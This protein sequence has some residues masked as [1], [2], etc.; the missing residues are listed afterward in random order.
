MSS[1]PYNFDPSGFIVSALT[2]PSGYMPPAGATSLP[3]THVAPRVNSFFGPNHLALT[4]MLQRALMGQAAQQGATASMVQNPALAR[5]QGGLVGQAFT[6]SMPSF[7]RVNWGPGGNINPQ[8]GWNA[9][10]MS[11]AG[12]TP[13]SGGFLGG[14]GL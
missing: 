11:Q 6:P 10:T 2:P 8:F 7:Q 4:Q 14:G 3:S 5:A 12:G 13:G 1:Y 9:P